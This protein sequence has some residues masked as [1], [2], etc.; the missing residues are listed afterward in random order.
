MH[1]KLINKV[2]V[3]GLGSIGRRHARVIRSLNKDVSISSYRTKKGGLQEGVDGVSEL[4]KDVFFTSRFDLVVISNP[5]SLHLETLKEVLEANIAK[6]IFVEKPF[7]LPGE[8]ME[9]M[10]LLAKHPE[11]RVLPGNCLRFHP[12]VTLL[13]EQITG[14]LLGEA[15]E[16]HAHFG[17]YLPGWHPYE[18]Y[19]VTYASR[20][21][22]GGGV[23]LTSIHEIDLVHHLF[24]KGAV[25]GSYSGRIALNEINVE[26]TAHLLMTLERCR[27]ANISLNYFERPADRFL[28]VIFENGTFFWKFSQPAVSGFPSRIRPDGGKQF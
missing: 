5:S 16:C 8:L 28:K 12:A 1:S 13:K 23:L 21:E 18:D 7:C 11:V 26:D 17:T 25:A 6:T 24:G 2:G 27:V 15:L 4:E 22:L 19:R 3:I 9:A 10:E 14:G 20:K